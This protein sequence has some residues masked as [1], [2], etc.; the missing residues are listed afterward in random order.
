ML[1]SRRRIR[2]PRESLGPKAVMTFQT[3]QLKRGRHAS[4]E[5]GVC[6][7]ELTSMLAGERFSDRP[8]CAC[9][10]LTGF[11]RGYN[12]ELDQQRRQDLYAVASLL[13]GSRCPGARTRQRAACLIGLAGSRPAHLGPLRWR[14]RCR[15]GATALRDC[16]RAGLHLGWCVRHGQCS[17]E[18][19][20]DTL[21]ELA[22][23]SA[24]D[25]TP[26]F[27]RATGPALG[28]PGRIEDDRQGHSA[29]SPTRTAADRSPGTLVGGSVSPRA[30]HFVAE[31]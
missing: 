2:P 21:G 23:D 30:H 9:P 28:T 31:R 16:E 25:P 18:L 8:S 26:T 1:R 29:A 11:L 20:L 10:A 17:H 14:F 13:V 27:R 12:D 3:V 24:V 5:E 4:P 6:V 15:Y 22:V 19:V 7:A